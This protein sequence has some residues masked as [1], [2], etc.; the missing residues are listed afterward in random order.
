M[1]FG[2]S[3]LNETYRVAERLGQ[4]SSSVINRNNSKSRGRHTRERSGLSGPFKLTGTIDKLTV[5]TVARIQPMWNILGFFC[6]CDFDR[7]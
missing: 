2:P 4:M 1:P 3:S 7:E 5:S 6:I